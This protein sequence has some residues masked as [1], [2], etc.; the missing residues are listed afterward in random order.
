MVLQTAAAVHQPFLPTV[1]AG[2]LASIFSHPTKQGYTVFA[3]ITGG[4]GYF[5]RG[6]NPIADAVQGSTGI[7]PDPAVGNGMLVMFGDG[8]EITASTG[9]QH[10]RFLL[11]SG[12]PI[13]EPVAWRGPIVMNSSEELT[14]AFDE[15]RQ[16]TFI[17]YQG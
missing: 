6:E 1:S 14:V 13:G 17:K 3:Y 8:D 12:K 16:G 5:C 10:V 15:Y 4:R 2:R 7:Q 11:I 9:A